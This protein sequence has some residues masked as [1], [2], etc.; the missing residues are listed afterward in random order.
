M[1]ARHVN[2]LAPA[3]SVTA[4]AYALR[5]SMILDRIASAV[6]E[7]LAWGVPSDDIEE[8]VRAASAA[9]GVYVIAE[10]LWAATRTLDGLGEPG[11][12]VFA[13]PEL[14]RYDWTPTAPAASPDVLIVP[15]PRLSP[16]GSYELQREALL[17]AAR[18]ALA[19]HAVHGVAHGVD[20]AVDAQARQDA[21]SGMETV[22]PQVYA[23]N[24]HFSA[25]GARLTG[26]G[27]RRRFDGTTTYATKCSPRLQEQ[28]GERGPRRRDTSP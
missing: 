25:P 2:S 13:L 7:A 11:F 14:V 3:Q 28:P 5:R 8:A 16:E 24:R 21:A 17:G 6:E 18:E 1:G 22:N 12:L 19:R 23:A 9:A 26:G 15:V 20:R 27:D 10:A 4:S